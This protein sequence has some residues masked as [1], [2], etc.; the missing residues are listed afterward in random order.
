MYSLFIW[1]SQHKLEHFSWGAWH[2]SWHVSNSFEAAAISLFCLWAKQ[3]DEGIVWK[4]EHKELFYVCQCR[5]NAFSIQKKRE[6][7]FG[8]KNK[9]VYYNL[10]KVSTLLELKYPEPGSNRH[11][12]P[13]WCLRPARLPI[14]PSGLQAYL[15]D[16]RRCKGTHIFW[17]SKFYQ[18]KKTKYLFMSL[19]ICTLVRF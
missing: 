6:P 1:F 14:P 19:F 15:F 11:G 16:E 5:I 8:I 9:E 12:L 10:L 4:K 3:R 13:H 17:I 7:K 18:R 2:S